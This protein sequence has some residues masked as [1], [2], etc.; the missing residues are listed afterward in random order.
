MQ[1]LYN[2]STL[3]ILSFIHYFYKLEAY[4]I[5]SLTFLKTK[6][7]GSKSQQISAITFVIVFIASPLIVNRML[8]EILFSKN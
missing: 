8:P 2:L 4:V 5:A 1:M 7:C 6:I 3:H